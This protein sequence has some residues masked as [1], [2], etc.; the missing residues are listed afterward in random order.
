MDYEKMDLKIEE[1]LILEKMLNRKSSK[2]K[3]EK[4]T[5]NRKIGQEITRLRKIDHEKWLLTPSG[6]QY[7]KITKSWHESANYGQVKK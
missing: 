2:L 4:F 3:I 1:L 5:I 7:T 6:K